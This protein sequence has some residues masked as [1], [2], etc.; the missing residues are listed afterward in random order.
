MINRK[1]SNWT[2]IQIILAHNWIRIVLSII[3]YSKWGFTTKHPSARWEVEK[4]TTHVDTVC[5]M[6]SACL[7]L[8]CIINRRTKHGRRWCS[9]YTH[10]S[11]IFI[12]EFLDMH[13]NAIVPPTRF[14]TK[15]INLSLFAI[16]LDFLQWKR[17]FWV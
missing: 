15:M 8:W 4:K 5:C 1:L 13:E 11:S 14:T 3:N 7:Y 10:A 17:V 16:F 2:K 9:V 12:I 6:H